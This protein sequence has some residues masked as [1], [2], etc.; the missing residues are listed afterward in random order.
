MPP[1]EIDASA[2]PP[3]GMPPADFLRDYWQ[4]RPL[5]IRNAFPGFVSPI[6]PED[7]AGLACEEMALSRIVSHD[8]D[9]DHW[10]LRTGPFREDEFPGMPHQDWTLLVQ[11]VD[12]WD[13][14][15][16]ALL[17]C[18]DFL[19]RW[20]IDDIMVSFAAPGGSVGAHVDQYD[21]F[22]LQAQGRRRW[23]IDASESPSLT[24]RR[25]VELKLLQRFSPTHDWVLGPGDMLYLP[26]GVPH[27]GVAED[28]C[29][30]FSVGMRA[31]SAA[32]LLGDFVDTLAAEADEALRYRDPDLEPPRDPAEIDVAAM[33]RAVEALNM[34]RMNDPERLGDW[35]GRFITLYRSSGE[36][37]AG[38]NGRSRIEI[39][40]DLQ[41]GARLVR[42]PWSRMAWRKGG[43]GSRLYVNG[44]AIAL[45][46]RAAARV[47]NSRVL[48]GDDYAALGQA[49]QDC[50]FE[51][52]RTGHYHLQMDADGDD[53]G[54][55]A[56]WWPEDGSGQ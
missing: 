12:K 41:H 51:L 31:P 6:E 52:Y 23:Q 48:D 5:L 15:V 16:A 53:G 32:E 44:H 39:E 56:T 38:E 30:T 21:V 3:L 42:H 49:G 2:L 45:P 40:W 50:V 1:V 11:D 17:D 18:F 24:F 33:N 29:L 47:A 7:L 19:P 28:A 55:G 35:F 37:I 13:A 54:N 25:D 10:R 34:L 4:K 46:A 14:D 36:V 9:R 20:R 8:R 43:R 22:L 27:H 26:P